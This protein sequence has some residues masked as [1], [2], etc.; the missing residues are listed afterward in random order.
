M[1]RIVSEVAPLLAFAENVTREAIDFAADD[2]ESLGYSVKCMSL[3]AADLGADHIRE[4]HWLLAYPDS[5]RELLRAIYAKV[6]MRARVFSSFWCTE[7]C[8]PRVADGLAF[9][10]EP[11]RATGDGQV[12]V[13][14]ASAFLQLLGSAAR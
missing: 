11:V 14:A 3:S 8:K 7:P 2:L 5:N 13:V 6:E 10:M 1:L 12:P 9:G 4:R